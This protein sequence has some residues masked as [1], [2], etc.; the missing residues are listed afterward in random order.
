MLE[1]AGRGGAQQGAEVVELHATV[2]G[3][4]A[5]VERR[6]RRARRADVLETHA[7]RP[8]RRRRVVVDVAAVADARVQRLAAAQQLQLL[9]PDAQQHG[10]HHVAEARR[11]EAQQRAPVRLSLIHI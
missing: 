1:P 11:V 5:H 10:Q 9:E 2:D 7:L 4:E 8:R 6:E 3:G